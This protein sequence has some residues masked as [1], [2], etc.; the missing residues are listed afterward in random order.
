MQKKVKNPMLLTFLFFFISISAIPEF[1]K[2]L[3]VHTSGS[4]KIIGLIS[5]VLISILIYLKWKYA[6]VLF[7]LVVVSVI[8]FDLLILMS[9]EQELFFNYSIL[10]LCHIGLLLIFTFSEKIQS[11]LIKQH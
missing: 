1:F 5:G 8:I 6:G 3:F 10:T 4:I 11:Y 7:Y 2:D 9:M